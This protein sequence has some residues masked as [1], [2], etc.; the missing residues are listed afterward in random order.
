MPHLSHVQ[1]IAAIVASIGVGISKAGF[2]GFSLLHVLIFAWLF[3]ARGSTGVVLPLLIFGDLSAVRTFHT[4]AQ[5]RYIRRMLPPAC[6]GVVVAAWFMSRL[7]DAAYKP[8]LG[9]MILGLAA[10]HLLRSARPNW[11]GNVPHSVG[12]AW[13]MGLLAGAMTMM[14]NAAGPIFAL[15]ALAIG[16][17]K[18]E[19]VGTGAWF[20]FI[21]NLIKVPFSIG[22]GLIQ[23]PTLFL[24]LVLLPPILLGVMVGRWLTRIVPQ[25]LFNRLL[26]MF[27]G[28]A[29]LRLLGLF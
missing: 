23:V 19:L 12:F 9:W 17:P 4:H 24:K 26:L 29:A 22:L 21:M 7:S 14:A 8:I 13:T 3:G 1:W 15:Y 25:E 16:L 6:I 18:F 2:S 11:F 20:F 27:A 28:I 5:W 10:L